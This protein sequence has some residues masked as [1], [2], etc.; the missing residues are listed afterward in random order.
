MFGLDDIDLEDVQQ[1]PH[2]DEFMM[3]FDD[4]ESSGSQH[5]T[6]K[7]KE[8]K[9]KKKLAKGISLIAIQSRL[10]FGRSHLQ[11]TSK[12]RDPYLVVSS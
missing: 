4:V 3:V 5:S 12:H 8:K 10:N 7:P 6:S 9:N 2:S 11:P 1:L